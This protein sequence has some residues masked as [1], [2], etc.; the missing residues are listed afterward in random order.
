[1][2]GCYQNFPLNVHAISFFEYLD[3]IKEIQKVIICTFYD[4]NQKT[5]DLGAVTP[6]LRQNCEVGFEFGVADGVD[7]VYLDQKELV[8]CIKNL[9]KSKVEILEVFFVV[10]YYRVREGGKRFPF[11]AHLKAGRGR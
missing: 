1:M 8:R 4:L 5:F 3:S 9:D 11:E 2:L 10:R 6:Y 7:F